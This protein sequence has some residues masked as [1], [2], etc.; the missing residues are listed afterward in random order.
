MIF[1]GCGLL[2]KIDGKVNQTLYKEILEVG[3]SS[4]ICLYDIDPRHVIFEQDNMPIHNSKSM[5]Q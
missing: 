2:I 1:Y 5:K 3:L 4:T